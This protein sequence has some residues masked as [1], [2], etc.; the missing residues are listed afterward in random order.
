VAGLVI[1]NRIARNEAPRQLGLSIGTLRTHLKRIYKKIGSP[2]A[3]ARQ[4][5]LLSW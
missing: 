2:D 1:L 3:L 5:T 4:L